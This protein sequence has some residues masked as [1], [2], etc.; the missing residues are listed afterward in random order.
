MNTTAQGMADG[1]GQ[2]TG[3]Q[4]QQQFYGYG[5]YH[6]RGNNGYAGQGSGEYE[7]RG[8][9]ADLRRNNQG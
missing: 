9:E 5:N 2:A 1:I 3:G 4:Q 8:S 6:H 7:N